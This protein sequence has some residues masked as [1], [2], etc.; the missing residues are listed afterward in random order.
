V[1]AHTGT[2]IYFSSTQL[3]G[4]AICYTRI[5]NDFGG[6]DCILRGTGKLRYRET[7]ETVNVN[8]IDC[9]SHG[10]IHYYCL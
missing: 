2:C 5:G 4:D 9:L 3:V 1:K 7:L 10:D 8:V 6:I